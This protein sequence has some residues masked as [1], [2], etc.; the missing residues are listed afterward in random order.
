MGLTESS[1]AATDAMIRLGGEAAAALEVDGDLAGLI[2]LGPKRSGLPYEE[3]EML[4]LGALS[5]VASLAVHAAEIQDTLAKL[6]SELRHKVEKIAE[7]QRRILILQGQL[8]DKARGV[9]EGE[10]T[11][12]A[13]TTSALEPSTTVEP[14][15]VFGRIK[16]SSPAVRRMIEPARKV[17]SSTSAVLI[18]GE[19]GTGKELLA[20]AIHATSP[21][22]QRP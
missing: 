1:D 13:S 7:Q 17:A 20:E 9:V 8:S 6:N 4:F 18:R 19:T 2:V 11:S 5:S 14:P 22:A 10:Q 3:E 12:D 15:S 21:R 16:G